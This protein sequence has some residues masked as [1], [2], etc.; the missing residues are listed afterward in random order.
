M[1]RLTDLVNVA[2]SLW[3]GVHLAAAI[4]LLAVS[5][6]AF[7]PAPTYRLWLLT[8][9]VTEYGHYFAPVALLWLWPGWHRTW[10]RRFALVCA[11]LAAA[12]FLSPVVRGL[13]LAQTL[14]SELNAA[15]GPVASD[16]RPDVRLRVTPIDP[17]MLFGAARVP[18]ST[19][20]VTTITYAVRDGQALALDLYRPAEQTGGRPAPI[21]MVIHGGGWWTGHRDDLAA[22]NLHLAERGYLVVA[23][24]YR[25]APAHEY[26]AAFDDLTTALAVVRGR[27]REWNADPERL[28]VIG[29]SAGAQLALLLGYRQ[30]GDAIRGVVS[31]YGPADLRFAWEHPG[32]AWVYDG[33]GTIERYLGGPP[34][35]AGARYDEASPYQYVGTTTP[36]TLLI[37]GQRDEIVWVAQ[38]TRLADRLRA[39]GRPHY[40][41]APGWAT[42]GCDYNFTGPCGQLSTFAI[43][44]FLAAVL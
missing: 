28:A 44:R 38:S 6:L 3:R 17:A 31:F 5:L 33:I 34:A 43:D 7:V 37:H 4:V 12:G 23:P 41:L 14:E 2:R 10:S 22:L 26:P 11:A 42:H 9:V 25:L 19:V 27:A 13:L 40:L 30:A 39:H 21:V 1:D 15:F 16:L 20:T 36:P 18:Q 8:I 32:N 35:Q 29:R 24:S